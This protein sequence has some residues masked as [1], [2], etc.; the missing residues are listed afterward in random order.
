MSARL[1]RELALEAL[2]NRARLVE[3]DRELQEML[4]RHPDAALIRGLPGMG[5][6]L[7]RNSSRRQETSPGSTSPTRSP[8]PQA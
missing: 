8:P 2:A 6:V 5:A 7:P 4:H 1:I 3:L